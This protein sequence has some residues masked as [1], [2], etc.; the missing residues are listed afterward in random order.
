MGG[1]GPRGRPGHRVA[2]VDGRPAAQA[3][4]TDLVL[5]SR[6]LD[7]GKLAEGLAYL[8]RSGRK[9]PHNR[10]VGPRLLSALSSH[11]FL[12]PTAASL[13]RE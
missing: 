1:A 9:D 13:Q 2:V 6:L 12:Q 11:S 10:L 5:G 3:G 8:V 7:E 4:Q